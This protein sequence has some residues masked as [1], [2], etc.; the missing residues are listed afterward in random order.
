MIYATIAYFAILL[1]FVLKNK[2][3]LGAAYLIAAYLLM[4]LFSI[5]WLEENSSLYR[6]TAV[7]S[8]VFSIM[9]LFYFHPF[10]KK[11]RML[12]LSGFKDE[13]QKNKFIKIGYTISIILILMMIMISPAISNAFDMGLE[14]VRSDMYAGESEVFSASITERLGRYMLKWMANLSY[15]MLIMFFYSACF[16]R[17]YTWLKVL[18]FV[19]S[20]S[21]IFYTMS[22][23]SRSSVIYYLLFFI[24]CLI[25]FYPY[26]NR[27]TKV[28][29]FSLVSVFL[30]LIIG[31]F[32]IVSTMRTALTGNDYLLTYAGQSYANFCDYFDN[33]NWHAYTLRRV[34]PLSSYLLG[35]KWSLAE[36]DIDVL[37][38]T[39]MELGK[40]S[41]MMG[42]I[43]IDLGL[44]GLLVYSIIYNRIASYVMKVR[45]FDL[46]QLL[47]LGIVIQVPLHGVFY[48]SLHTVEASAAILM[49]L[50]IGRHI[51]TNKLSYE[52]TMG[53]IA[54]LVLLLQVS[55]KN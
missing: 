30:T 1:V 35:G 40:F 44:I 55:S 25:L 14:D 51:R 49:T 34:L 39:G 43:F 38:K 3:W 16:L 29:T 53:L 5:G 7:P 48:Y 2:Y 23:G 10:L 4:L 52:V 47:L 41:T 20:I 8:V 21:R 54:F 24:V 27:K 33:M 18:L 15:P 6:P 32:I 37:N 12:Q 31:Y 45:S 28:L 50:L 13:S 42:T 11:G 9:I 26:L 46:T 19:S 17:G 36:Y 22:V